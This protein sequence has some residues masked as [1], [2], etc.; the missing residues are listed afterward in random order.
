MVLQTASRDRRGP[1]TS[2][3]SPEIE[4]WAEQTINSQQGDVILVT[5]KIFLSFVAITLVKN[6]SVKQTVKDSQ[7]FIERKENKLMAWKLQLLVNNVIYH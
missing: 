5:R 3:I 1:Y 2:R 6:I 4:L 7:A